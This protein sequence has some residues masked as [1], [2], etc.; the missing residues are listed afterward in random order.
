MIAAFVALVALGCVPRQLPRR[1]ATSLRTTAAAACAASGFRC[2]RNW[3]DPSIALALVLVPAHRT[4]RTVQR[5]SCSV[6]RV[7]E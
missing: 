6:E 5:R 1:A 4:L 7:G 2:K 3:E